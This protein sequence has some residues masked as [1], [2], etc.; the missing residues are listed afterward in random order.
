MR[1]EVKGLVEVGGR[2]QRSRSEV[3]VRGQK[4]EINMTEARFG[5]SDEEVKGKRLEEEGGG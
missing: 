2:D 3:E 4:S 5:G 1:S